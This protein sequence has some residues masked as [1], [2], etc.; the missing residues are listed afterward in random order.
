MKYTTAYRV[1]Y[2]NGCFAL[3]VTNLLCHCRRV[4]IAPFGM[5]GSIE[6]KGVITIITIIIEMQNL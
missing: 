6:R 5:K 1:S 4:T 3:G 2:K